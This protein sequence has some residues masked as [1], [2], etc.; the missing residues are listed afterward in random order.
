M[1]CQEMDLS[2]Y[3]RQAYDG[4]AFGYLLE[5]LRN[6]SFQ[7]SDVSYKLLVSVVSVRR[8][9]NLSGILCNPASPRK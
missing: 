9:Q 8:S 1:G 6:E 5:M 4:G 2:A 3:V 7:E